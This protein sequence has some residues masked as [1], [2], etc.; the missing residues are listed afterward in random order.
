MKRAPLSL[1]IVSPISSPL[2]SPRAEDEKLLPGEMGLPPLVRAASVSEDLW[3]NAANLWKSVFF[4]MK[5]F[6]K[7]VVLIL[8]RLLDEMD[9]IAIACVS[10]AGRELAAVLARC[11]LKCSSP[12]DEIFGALT[13]HDSVWVDKERGGHVVLKRDGTFCCFSEGSSRA[14]MGAWNYYGVL[15]GSWKKVA[16]SGRL[17]DCKMRVPIVIELEG[18]EFRARMREVWFAMSEHALS[19]EWNAAVASGRDMSSR[20]K[21]TYREGLVENHPKYLLRLELHGSSELIG[22]LSSEE[23]SPVNPFSFW[24]R[25]EKF[26]RSHSWLLNWRESTLT[27]SS[28]GQARYEKKQ[29][30]ENLVQTRMF[31]CDTK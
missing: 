15:L 18:K 21:L 3:K 25:A 22:V 24:E 26:V 20:I 1:S 7:D 28:S 30:L 11:L 17:P 12:W 19:S 16:G 27:W 9:L 6:P 29:I 8:A 23:I 4:G 14:S 31:A 13:L 2:G 5:A 10:V